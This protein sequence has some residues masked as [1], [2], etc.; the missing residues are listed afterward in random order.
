M[1]NNNIKEMNL[2]HKNQLPKGSSSAHFKQSAKM[3]K[4]IPSL[5][6][7]LSVSAKI[8]N[9]EGFGERFKLFSTYST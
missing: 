8:P 7:I 4:Q 3:Q 9:G 2:Y 5:F 1:K 6:G